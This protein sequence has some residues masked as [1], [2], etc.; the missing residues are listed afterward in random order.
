MK[1]FMFFLGL[2]LMMSVSGFSQ[3]TIHG[4]SGITNGTEYS[5]LNAAF[6]AINA[7]A[8]QSGQDIEVRIN[9]ST[10]ETGRALLNYRNWNSLVVYPTAADLSVSANF[11]ESVIRLNG[12]RNVTIDGRVNRAGS[13]PSL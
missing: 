3:I 13:S 8:S 11:T 2:F 9:A 4:A 1:K 6:S 12:V 10:T 5:T 7:T